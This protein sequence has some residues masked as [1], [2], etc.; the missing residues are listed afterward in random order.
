MLTPHKI[1]LEFYIFFFNV[2]FLSYFCLIE[3][4]I[5]QHE[6]KHNAL[7]L[8]EYYDQCQ[9]DNK[10]RLDKFQDSKVKEVCTFL[11]Y[12]THKCNE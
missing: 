11:T 3:A 4:I 7:K 6:A 8:A 2:Y 10:T 5:D 1:I 9:H 12:E